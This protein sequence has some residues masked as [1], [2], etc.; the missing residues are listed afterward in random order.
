MT[1]PAS[2]RLCKTIMTAEAHAVVSPAATRLAS[3]HIELA[4]T[5]VSKARMQNQPLT[6]MWRTNICEEIAIKPYD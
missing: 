1:P 2:P 4:K 3:A 5:Y 6:A